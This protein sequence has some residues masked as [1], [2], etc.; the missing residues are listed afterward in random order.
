MA[1]FSTK[2]FNLCVVLFC[3]DSGGFVFI[4]NGLFGDG[5]Q[6]TKLS[7]F[8]YEFNKSLKF[9]I[10]LKSSSNSPTKKIAKIG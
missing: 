3:W 1:I 5:L 4:S 8:F 2:Q 6:N 9:L 10:S 7:F